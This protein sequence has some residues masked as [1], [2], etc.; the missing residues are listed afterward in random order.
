MHSSCKLSLFNSVADSLLA[1]LNPKGEQKE[2]PT[3][4]S[5]R[6]SQKD[7]E[8]YQDLDL[9][10]EPIQ[11]HKQK[12]PSLTIVNPNRPTT[13]QVNRYQWRTL[14]TQFTSVTEYSTNFPSNPHLITAFRVEVKE[15]D[16]T[17]LLKELYALIVATKGKTLEE[18]KQQFYSRM[19]TLTLESVNVTY[20]TT[21]CNQLIFAS[22][23]DIKSNKTGIKI[24]RNNINYKVSLFCEY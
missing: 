6:K 10:S 9:Q 7:F 4:T 1:E 18:V 15:K 17:L 12:T 5:K 16:Y 22:V 20:W 24:T 8:I 19:Y 2:E 14:S 3:K 21:V 11:S 23:L 13:T